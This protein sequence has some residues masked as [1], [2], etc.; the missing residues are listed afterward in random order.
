[1][2]FE[3]ACALVDTR[4]RAADSGS[5][6]IL[7]QYGRI[8]LERIDLFFAGSVLTSDPVKLFLPPSRLADGGSGRSRRGRGELPCDTF[9]GFFA[10]GIP[11]WEKL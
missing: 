8:A 6:S 5:A 9:P 3:V 11:V 7:S 4:L 10:R 1:M 2:T